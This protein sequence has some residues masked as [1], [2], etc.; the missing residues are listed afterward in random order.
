MNG[1]IKQQFVITGGAG[2]IG[3]HFTAELLNKG[4]SVLAIDNLCSG[5][6]EH[7]RPF[8]SNRN[9]S[10]ELMNVEDT[11]KLTRLLINTDTVIHLASNPD[12][13][14]SVSEPRIDF[15]QGTVLTESIAEAARR[16]NVKNIL[17]AS[18][19]GVYGDAGEA[20]LFENSEL[21]PIS[22]YGASKLAGEA[23]LSSYSYMFGIKTLS[24]RFANVVGGMQTHGVGYDFLWKLKN[25]KSKLEILGNGNQSKSYVHVKDIISGVLTAFSRSTRLNDVFNVSTSDELSVTEIAYLAITISGLDPKSVEL[26]YSGGDRGWKADVPV[27]RLNS[28]KLRNLGWK[29]QFTSRSAMH[30]ALTVMSHNFKR[31]LFR[32]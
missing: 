10:F 15:A 24:F 26:K 30:D 9:F 23:L 11:E 16:A 31:V 6:Q 21:N 5:T 17:Y 2:F 13:A 28:S 20:I 18:G 22:T 25:D 12:I 3:S 19:S 1:F 29:T 7:L 14:K 27:V 8:L 32:S 4:H